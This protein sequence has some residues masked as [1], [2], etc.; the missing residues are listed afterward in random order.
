ML[1]PSNSC[2]LHPPTLGLLQSHRRSASVTVKTQHRLYTLNRRYDMLSEDIISSVCGP[3]IA[4]NT[5]VSKDIG[6]YAHS[7]TPSWATKSTFKKSSAPRH[8]VAVSETHIFAAQDQKAHVHVYSR[9]RGNQEALVAFPERIRS[10]ALAHNVLI[11]GTSEGRLILWEVSICLSFSLLRLLHNHLV[12]VLSLWSELS[13]PK[14]DLHRETNHD[15]CLSCPGSHLLSC[16]PLSH[17]F[18][19]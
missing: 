2:W 8:C 1:G 14:T 5:A 4:A 17:S 6:I 3:P 7:L 16:H 10:L 15:T 18:S 13:N 12:A 11:L 19:I 9:D